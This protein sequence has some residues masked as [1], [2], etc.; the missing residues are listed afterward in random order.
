MI[1]RYRLTGTMS[2]HYPIPIHFQLLRSLS[3]IMAQQLNLKHTHPC[4]LQ[5]L[6]SYSLDHATLCGES[7]AS[8]PRAQSE[9]GHSATF[10]SEPRK[11]S[12]EEC[13]D[14]GLRAWLVVLGVC[15][16][17]WTSLWRVIDN[18]LGFFCYFCNVSSFQHTTFL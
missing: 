13:P 3:H 1:S 15:L 4:K 5:P 9:N 17:T 7:V 6:I 8:H 11:R 2:S 14:G 18:A 12:Q 16:S 10:D